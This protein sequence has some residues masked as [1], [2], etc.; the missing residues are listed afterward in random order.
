MGKEAGPVDMGKRLSWMVLKISQPQLQRASN[1]MRR[2]FLGQLWVELGGGW[3]EKTGVEA[4][5]WA[6]QKQV[7]RSRGVSYLLF[8]RDKTVLG[9]NRNKRGTIEETTWL[10]TI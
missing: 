7:Y 10:T 4:M 5:A 6:V 8:L 9:N 3:G 2:M 1:F